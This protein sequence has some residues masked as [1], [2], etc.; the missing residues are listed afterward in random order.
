MKWIESFFSF[1]LII[2]E[3]GKDLVRQGSV[4]SA[5]ACSARHHREVCPTELKSDVQGLC[6]EGDMGQ[7][8]F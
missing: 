8:D 5:S 4:G 6:G 1:G 3:L 7:T 2:T